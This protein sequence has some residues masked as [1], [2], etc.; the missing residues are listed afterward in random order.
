[1]RGFW[2]ALVLALSTWI[3]PL[4]AGGD[5]PA[6]ELHLSAAKGDVAAIR[7]LLAEGASIDARDAQELPGGGPQ[8]LRARQDE[9]VA[10]LVGRR[11]DVGAPPAPAALVSKVHARARLTPR[12]RW[13]RTLPDRRWRTV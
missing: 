12:S 1:M 8:A 3:A 11:V 7:D 4:T 10:L 6:R 9:V 13:R 5:M 2:L